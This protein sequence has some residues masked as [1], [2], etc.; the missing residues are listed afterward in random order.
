MHHT[1]I[2]PLVKLTGQ[3]V[4]IALSAL[5]VSCLAAAPEVYLLWEGNYRI[6]PLPAFWKSPGLQV[7]LKILPMGRSHNGS[8]SKRP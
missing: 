3:C 1:M 4:A 8:S 6:C 7:L 2:Q 5:K